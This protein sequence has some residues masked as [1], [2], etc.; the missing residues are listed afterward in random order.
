[1]F[2]HIFLESSSLKAENLKCFPTHL[3]LTFFSTNAKLPALPEWSVDNVR[4]HILRGASNLNI[5]NGQVLTNE[6][7]GHSQHCEHLLQYGII[8]DIVQYR[9]NLFSLGSDLGR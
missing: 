7:L 1:M 9:S 4:V 6:C 5:I 3:N 8:I 2:L